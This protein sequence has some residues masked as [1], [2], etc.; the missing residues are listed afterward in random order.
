MGGMSEFGLAEAIDAVHA[1]APSDSD[2]I[3]ELMRLHARLEAELAAAVARW[4]ANKTWAAEGAKS[5]ASWLA[6]RCRIDKRKAS[7]LLRL[8]RACREMPVTERAWLAGEVHAEHVAV[9]AAVREID[10]FAGDEAMLVDDAKT[11]RYPQFV[12]TVD[13]WRL[14]HDPDDAEQLAAKQVEDRRFDL[15]QTFG[16]VWV[17]DLQSDPVSGEILDVTLRVIE[18]ELWEADWADAKDRL[19]RDPLA[20]ELARTPKQRRHDALVEMAKRART[21]PKD[22][23]RPEPLF[24]VLVGE[25]RFNELCELWS[26]TVIPPAALAPFMSDGWVER[27]VFDGPSRVI[28]VG[29][30]RRIFTG[31]TRRAVAV[32]DRVNT[33][34]CFDELCD[35]PIEHCQIDHIREYTAGGLT[36][37]LNGR[38]ACGFHNRLRNKRT[39]RKPTAD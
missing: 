20:H 19:G 37:Q 28:D 7:R 18:Q 13:Y 35:S 15:S 2:S 17:G 31:A 11:M 25:D 24:T 34:S 33:G 32:R 30:R 14:L 29:V 26:G 5:P 39:K 3:R 38:C 10:G 4:D 12:K 22:G 23:R 9:L 27:V 1:A 8:G 36:V 21:A 16:G 6:I